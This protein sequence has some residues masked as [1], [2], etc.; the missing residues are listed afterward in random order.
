[1]NF[2]TSSMLKPVYS[3]ILSSIPHLKHGFFTRNGGVSLPPYD[4]LN[5]SILHDN[6]DHV[7]ENRRR[8]QDFFKAP[9]VIAK[10]V[11]GCDV[12]KID[13]VPTSSL[14]ADGMV[15][16]DN[17]L[18]LGVLT[19]D[20][21][22]LL[23]ADPLS[24]TTAVTHAG[25]RGTLA[26]VIENTRAYFNHP[27]YVAIGPCIQQKSFEVGHDV[28]DAFIHKDTQ[29]SSFFKPHKDLYLFDL[30]GYIYGLLKTLNI[31]MIDWIQEDTYTLPDK[32]FSYRRSCHHD[33]PNSGNMVSAIIFEKEI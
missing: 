31:M 29:A 6:S 13:H 4:S 3:P 32:Y 27:P 2:K 26:G 5:M 10:Q 30:P 23:W 25:W 22:P 8:V 7:H 14:T 12:K 19:A 24:R 20:C 1:M 21:V 28:Y 33:Q 17:P 16:Y 9:L 15:N 18:V 11:H